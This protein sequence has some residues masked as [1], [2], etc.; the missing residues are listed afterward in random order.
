MYVREKRG[1][2]SKR[3]KIEI[4]NNLYTSIYGK[5]YLG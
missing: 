1:M 3:F 5:G 4:M 2:G